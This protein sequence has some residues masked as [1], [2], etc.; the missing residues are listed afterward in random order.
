MKALEVFINGQRVCLA[1]VGDNGVLHTIVNWV[2]RPERS[3][4]VDREARTNEDEE[5][6]WE[7]E[8]VFLSIGGLNSETREHYRWNT[9]TINVGDEVQIKIR[10]AENVDPPNEKKIF[11]K[12][13]CVSEYRQHLK[14]SSGW[15]TP[16]ERNQMIKE[17]VVELQND[18]GKPGDVSD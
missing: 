18:D 17:L 10:E 5:D 1:G 13:T 3:D 7:Q 11:E 16:E 4:E 12:R 14:E 2:G 15:L 8:E 6:D 9:P